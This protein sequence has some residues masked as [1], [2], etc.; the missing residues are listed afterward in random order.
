MWWRSFVQ[1]ATAT[2][3]SSRWQA[4]AGNMPD[5]SVLAYTMEKLPEMS[6]SAS[7]KMAKEMEH[8]WDFAA[9]RYLQAITYQKSALDELLPRV[10]RL[11]KSTH[12]RNLQI[13]ILDM[14]TDCIVV[15]DGD[16]FDSETLPIVD[17][18]ASSKFPS[19]PLDDSAIATALGV[20]MQ[21]GI[22]DE[23]LQFFSPNIFKG[24]YHMEG[25]LLSLH[26]AGSLNGGCNQPDKRQLT[27]QEF[28]VQTKA[29]YLARSLA[30]MRNVLVSSK[31]CCVGCNALVRFANALPDEQAS[32]A[33]ELGM[34]RPEERWTPCTI[35]PWTPRAA[36]Q[37]MLDEAEAELMELVGEWLGEGES[38]TQM[39][40]DEDDTV[41]ATADD[42]ED[43]VAEKADGENGKEES[44]GK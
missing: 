23:N 39:W 20:A 14:K 33:T 27:P 22:V 36:A 21:K 30:D 41:T 3:E 5:S 17:V 19:K 9:M 2:S 13:K 18:L 11:R 31:R 38:I 26:L 34:A 8:T 15:Q 16:A 7:P 24:G 10:N 42:E 32:W 43:S 1:S 44:S 12:S 6:S 40:L 29:H 28:A 35:P 37:F 25:V 4:T